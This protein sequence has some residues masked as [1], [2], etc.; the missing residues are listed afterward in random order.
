[1]GLGSLLPKPMGSFGGFGFSKGKRVWAA[2]DLNLRYVSGLH[3]LAWREICV[4][5]DATELSETKLLASHSQT[6]VI[7]DKSSCCPHMQ[8]L[9]A[10]A[11]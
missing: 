8:D 3:S 10:R 2:P 4:T 1:M 5:L 7:D 11:T 6:K 9:T